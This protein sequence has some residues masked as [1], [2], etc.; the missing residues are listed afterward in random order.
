MDV[1][2]LKP[3]DL[4][5]IKPAKPFPEEKKINGEIPRRYYDTCVFARVRQVDTE[6]D[7]VYIDEYTKCGGML[8]CGRFRGETGLVDYDEVFLDGLPLRRVE[9]MRMYVPMTFTEIK[10]FQKGLNEALENMT[11]DKQL[12]SS[13]SVLRIEREKATK[14]TIR[15]VNDYLEKAR[16]AIAPH[17]N[18]DGR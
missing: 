13:G 12:L 18:Y 4:V 8:L 2:K 9:Q 14:D 11:F 3:N 16:G 5:I 17:L 6:H 10:L 15:V 7:R 1:Y